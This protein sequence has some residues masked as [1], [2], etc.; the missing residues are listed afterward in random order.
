MT[1]ITKLSRQAL[2]FGAMALGACSFNIENPNT[3]DIIGENPNRSQVAST[4]S[5]SLGP[6]LTG[7]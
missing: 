4:P 6:P 5:L 3:P 1:T 7:A 2:V